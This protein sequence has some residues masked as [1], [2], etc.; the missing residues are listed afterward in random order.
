MPETTTPS[1]GHRFTMRIDFA[2]GIGPAA[3]Q[4][5][6][7]LLNS[8]DSALFSDTV[9]VRQLPGGA[10]NQNYVVTSAT[11][12]YAL[13]IANQDNERMAVD[14]DSARRAQADAAALG[15]A[16]AV[17]AHCGGQGHL[18]SE[19]VDGT[20]LSTATIGDPEVLAAI[21]ATFHTLHHGAS[22]CRTFD[23]FADI[24]MWIDQA[25]DSG[26]A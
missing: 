12:R 26:V 22:S 8:W 15:V 25:A 9:A 4:Q 1:S 14:R 13:R 2:S 16:P 10:N 5:V 19:F 17:L 20:A 7:T 3:R 11:R 23:P 21:A 24:E 18:L 6:L